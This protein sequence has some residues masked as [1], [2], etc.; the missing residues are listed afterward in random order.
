MF[1]TGFSFAVAIVYAICMQEHLLP[2]YGNITVSVCAGLLFGL[3]TMLIQYVGIFVSGLHLGLS[4]IAT[5]VYGGALVGMS[6]DYYIDRWAMMK[7]LEPV[8]PPPCPLSWLALAVWPICAM[9]GIIIQWT[10][11]GTGVRLV[12]MKRRSKGALVHLTRE[13]R[14]EMRQRK[15]RYLYQ[16]RTAHG[17][18]I[19]QSYVQALQQK[20]SSS[21]PW[22]AG[23]TGECSTLQSDSTHLTVLASDIYWSAHLNNSAQ[24]L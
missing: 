24:F 14:A 9:F 23:G 20:N 2:Q 18:V 12:V 10:L 19:S 8:V 11:T 22:N 21:E 1:S 7:W 16:V 15:Y 6:L 4:I 3:I 17:D 13:Q 5:S